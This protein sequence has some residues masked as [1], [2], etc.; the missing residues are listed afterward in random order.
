MCPGL[1]GGVDRLYLYLVQFQVFG[2]FSEP[3]DDAGCHIYIEI[4]SIVLGLLIS[5]HTVVTHWTLSQ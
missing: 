2:D 4:D 1:T 3:F 5:F